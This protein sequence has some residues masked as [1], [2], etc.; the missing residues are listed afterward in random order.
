MLHSV[1]KVFRDIDIVL[2][3]AL[4]EQAFLY[5]RSLTLAD[6][7]RD[8]AAVRGV[9]AQLLVELIFPFAEL[10]HSRGG[11]YAQGIEAG[12]CFQRGARSRRVGIECV[13]YDGD[14]AA[15]VEYLHTVRN[16]VKALHGINEVAERNAELVRNGDSAED[17]LYVVLAEKLRVELL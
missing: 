7:Y 4:C 13:V 5:R 8:I 3:E 2:G 9:F 10:D 1:V 14:A 6:K 16:G 11:K 17:I 12:Q 15:L